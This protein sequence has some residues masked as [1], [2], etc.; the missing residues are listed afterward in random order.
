MFSFLFK[1]RRR[2]QL[3]ASPLSDTARQII[4]RNVAVYPLLSPAEQQRLTNA[5]TIIAAERSFVGCGGLVISDEV[6]L[7]IAA[8]AA[9]VL[10]GEAGYYFDRVPTIFVYPHWP[11]TKVKRV[12]QEAL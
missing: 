2:K 7:T 12:L 6:K 3:L 5:A 8:Q 1:N 10:L 9:L 4:E 11:T